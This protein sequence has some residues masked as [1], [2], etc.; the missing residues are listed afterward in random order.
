MQ[1]ARSREF[2]H[3]LAPLAARIFGREADPAFSVDNFYQLNTQVKRGYIRGDADEVTYPAHVI[4]RY[5]IERALIQ[6][7]IEVADIPEMWDQ[8]MQTYLGLSTQNNYRDGCMQDI[9]WTDGAFG[10][11][12]SYTLGAI[13]AAQLFAAADH[14]TSGLQEKI[15]RGELSELFAWLKTN[16][17]QKAST[18]STDELIRSATGEGLNA[19]YFQRHL[20]ARYL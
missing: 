1:L 13:Y 8:K 2:S 10:Y 19:D 12:P 11:F 16:I 17:W 3:Q 7:D 15:Q 5:E 6:G 18:L 20:T 9:H 14:S 4:L